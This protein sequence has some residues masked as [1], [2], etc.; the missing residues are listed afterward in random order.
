MILPE[1]TL[2][3]SRLE[4]PIWRFLRDS[5][6]SGK[7]TVRSRFFGGQFGIFMDTCVMLCPQFCNEPSFE[8]KSDSEPELELPISW[9]TSVSDSLLETF[10]ES[11]W[12][13]TWCIGD[14]YCWLA[15][16]WLLPIEEVK[17]KSSTS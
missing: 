2:V 3:V 15:I 12:S 7:H 17:S 4:P 11:S 5:P 6:G 13:L 1:N 9:I 14:S 10:M 16:S 8:V